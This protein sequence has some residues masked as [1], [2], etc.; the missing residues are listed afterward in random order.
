MTTRA[1]AT[2][3]ANDKRMI[4]NSSKIAADDKFN[5]G[6]P[7]TAAHFSYLEQL[8]ACEPAKTPTSSGRKTQQ[9][10]RSVSKR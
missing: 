10:S 3:E 2:I 4:R 7:V 9:K 1:E 8:K 6:K 5:K